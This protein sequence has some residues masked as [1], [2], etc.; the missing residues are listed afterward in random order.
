MNLLFRYGQEAY[1]LYNTASLLM[2]PDFQIGPAEGGF[3]DGLDVNYYVRRA[4][5]GII[6]GLW[7]CV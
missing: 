3:I 4:R 2:H 7:G 1:D 5:F 6:L